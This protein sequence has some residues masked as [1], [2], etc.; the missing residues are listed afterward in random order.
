VLLFIYN[1]WYSFAN[2][3]LWLLNILQ[4][5]TMSFL[6]ITAFYL[7]LPHFI[8]IYENLIFNLMLTPKSLS[9]L[10]PEVSC[11]SH[12]KTAWQTNQAVLN[13]SS[14]TTAAFSTCLC[15]HDVLTSARQELFCCKIH[16]ALCIE[17]TPKVLHNGTLESRIPHWTKLPNKPADR[18]YK[19]HGRKLP[20]VST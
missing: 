4:W 11:P 18:V 13:R 19:Y 12:P 3:F 5:I 2:V 20:P 14:L 8:Y 9:T 7:Q 6:Y 15:F 16:K 1:S 17:D 10:L